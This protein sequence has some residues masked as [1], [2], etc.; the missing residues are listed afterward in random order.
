MY[1]L[2][3]VLLE[4]LMGR[5]VGPNTAR[6]VEKAARK[7]GIGSLVARADAAWPPAVAGKLAELA[8]RCIA[9]DEEDRPESVEKV[10]A[11]L[12]EVRELLPV[13]GTLPVSTAPLSPGKAP[14]DVFAALKGG[15]ALPLGAPPLPVDTPAAVWKEVLGNDGPSSPASAAT[16]M[17][18]AYSRGGGSA[19]RPSPPSRAHLQP[20]PPPAR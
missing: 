14:W 12:A 6:E 17:E 8:I 18:S 20:L 19:R 3:V 7:G 1:A 9:A 16:E 4:A 10:A 15:K 2:G 11:A 5:R 13:R